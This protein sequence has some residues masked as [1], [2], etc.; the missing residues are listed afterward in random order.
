MKLALLSDPSSTNGINAIKQ[1]L[2]AL[3]KRAVKVGYIASEPEPDRHYFRQTQ[4]LYK[5]LGARL[6]H[7]L[8]L[9][10]GFDETAFVEQLCCDVIHL[11]GGDTFRF[12]KGLQ[13]RGLIPRLRENVM[14]GGALIGV[15]AGAM[16][17]T[18]SIESAPLCGD[19]N[20]VGLDNLS[21]LGVTPFHFMPHL[22]A[23]INTPVDFISTLTERNIEFDD[24]L[25]E[26]LYLC[27]DN[28]AVTLIDG[29]IDE[30]G[31]PLLW[32]HCIEC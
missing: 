14:A 13:H 24:T 19:S 22:S 27:Q 18:P 9:E 6:E 7:Y 8:E 23:D 29:V 15:S 3:Q 5:N 12:L 11:A 26:Q 1:V 30:L 4:V 31:G 20:G 25:L 17:M 16:I 28:A 2:A 21:A 10:T 32:T